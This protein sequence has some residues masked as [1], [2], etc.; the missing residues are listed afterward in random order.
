MNLKKH[1][2]ILLNGFIV[3]APLL[4]TVYVVVAALLGL[5]RLVRAALTPLWFSP[6]QRLSEHLHWE[7]PLPG[8]GIVVGV[9]AI[10][11]IGLVARSWFFG[12]L[13]RLGEG[14]V[15]RI[16]LVKSVYSAVRD[17]LQ[18]LG[19]TKKEE[20]GRPAILASKDGTV[21]LLGLVTQEQPERLL[22]GTEGRVA[23][24]LPMSYQI[25][26]FMVLVDRDAVQEIKGVSVEDVLKLS[27]TAGIGAAK[28]DEE[29]R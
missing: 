22:P 4:V 3:V 13:M 24:Y 2:T 11:F 6:L 16:P 26:G 15:E 27:L 9:A 21:Q 7:G 12:I 1:G 29:K 23:V 17:L 18:F 25:G 19:G 14:I 8:I 5:D 28:G 10:Y 20:R